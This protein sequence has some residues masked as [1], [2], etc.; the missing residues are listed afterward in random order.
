MQIK[1]DRDVARFL[2]GVEQE[3]RS[4]GEFRRCLDV[5][6]ALASRSVRL[7]GFGNC[8]SKIASDPGADFRRRR[9]QVDP[10]RLPGTSGR[11]AY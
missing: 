8:T 11:A 1:R 6:R 4:A 7:L 9:D 2:L 3:V 5:K 10:D